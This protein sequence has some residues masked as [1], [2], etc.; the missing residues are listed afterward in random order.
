MKKYIEVDNKEV[1]VL[2]LLQIIK[3]NKE[4]IENHNMAIYLSSSYIKELEKRTYIAKSQTFANTFTISAKCKSTD[5]HYGIMLKEENSQYIVIEA[6]TKDP[7]FDGSFVK[8]DETKP[9]GE[10]HISTPDRS[11]LSK[12]NR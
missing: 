2:Q 12:K 5:Y 10:L 7:E 1:S 4:H 11:L 6:R 9:K 3:T 8:V